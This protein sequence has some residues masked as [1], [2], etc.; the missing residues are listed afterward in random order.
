[1]VLAEVHALMVGGFPMGALARTRSLHETAVTAVL[2]A[3]HGR[4]P[5]TADLGE[6]FLL[7]AGIDEARDFALADSLGLEVDPAELDRVRDNRANLVSRYGRM[8]AKDYGWA[9]PLVPAISAS[10]RVSFDQL[11]ALASSGLSRLNYRLGGHHVHASAWTIQLTTMP[12]GGQDY[13]LTGP[14]NVGFAG[15]AAIALAAASVSTGAVIRGLKDEALDPM[16]LVTARALELM[17]AEAV[18][19]FKA[20]QAIVDEREARLH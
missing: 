12:R 16:D 1:L 19:R 18:A 17:S 11:E 8:Y 5:A 15:P 6:R 9:R 3:D 2:L 13:R 20:C 7:H 10:A 14:T 4:A